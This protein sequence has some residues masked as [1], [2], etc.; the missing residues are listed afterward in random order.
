MSVPNQKTIYIHKPRQEPFLQI[1]IDMLWEAYQRIKTPSSFALYLYLAS[2]QD[3]YKFELSKQAFM[4]ATY[5]S[6]SSYHRAVEHLTKLGYIYEDS[7][8][9]L[10]FGTKPK[11]GS[12]T[13]IQIWEEEDVELGHPIVKNETVESQNCK[14]PIPQVNTEIDNNI[15]NNRENTEIDSASRSS[16]DYLKEI[17][18]PNGE[19]IG[20][21]KKGQWLE[22]EVPNLWLLLR[23]KDT[24]LPRVIKQHTDFLLHEAKYISEKILKWNSRMWT[25]RE[26]DM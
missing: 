15:N 11:E 18:A 9:R 4:N 13:A 14:A 25:F 3:G 5:I 19:Y 7:C 17:I 23:N 12:R 1:G 8:G 10:N 6:K 2:N 26:G 22:D 21:E 24:R 20:G 16:L